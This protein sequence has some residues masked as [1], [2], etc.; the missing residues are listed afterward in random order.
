MFLAIEEM[1]KNKLRYGLIFG[2]LFLIAYLVFFLTGLAYGLMQDNRTAI[3]KWKADY[4]ILSSESNKLLASSRI[5]EEEYLK[6]EADNKGL[7]GQRS[8]SVWQENAAEKKQ[9][10]LLGIE[11]NSFLQPNIIEGRTAESKHEVVVDKSLNQKDDYKIGSTINV[12]GTDEKLVIVGYTD[13]A[14]L[15]V[16]PVVYLDLEDFRK[17]TS[18]SNP[19]NQKIVSAVVVKGE[20]KTELGEK[21]E[22]VPI[23]EFIKKLPGYNAQILTFGFMIGFLVVI[24]AVVIGIFIFVLTSQKS[25]IFGLMKI[26]GLSNLY[27]SKSVLYQTFLLSFSGT[28]TGL[29][30]TYLSSLILPQAVPFEN[31]Y[32]FYIGI[33][34]AM[35]LFALV[36][37][38]FSVRIIF[39]VDPLK[40][41]N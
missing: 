15:S 7:V 39:K 21:L 17:I 19:M 18:T 28:M 9:I 25:Q 24:A 6:I 14:Y 29:L 23:S 33:S 8:L 4:I 16:T 26:Q 37:A 2:L 40:S 13:N 35:V 36:G 12:S 41:L 22:L 30:V 31:N 3:D 27:I 38:I 20:M 1:R 34:I 11:K 10:N 5:L 32:L